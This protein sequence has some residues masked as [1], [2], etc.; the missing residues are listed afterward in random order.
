[1]IFMAKVAVVGDKDS[2]LAFKAL[3]VD[4]YSPIGVQET[5]SSLKKLA[6]EDYGVIFI[7]ERLA[8]GIPE[9]IKSYDEKPLPSIVL[10]PDNQGTIGIGMNTINRNMEKAIGMNIF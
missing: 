3:G 4:V 7:T 5:V 6:A 2:V 9:V 8:E 10:I 1:M